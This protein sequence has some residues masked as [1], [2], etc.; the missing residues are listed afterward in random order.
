MA[1]GRNRLFLRAC[2]LTA[3]STNCTL[4][5]TVFTARCD[6]PWSPMLKNPS[7]QCHL[8]KWIYTQ[9]HRVDPSSVS[10]AQ[11]SHSA[12]VFSSTLLPPSTPL[13]RNSPCRCHC[14]SPPLAAAIAA[15]PLL[16]RR[17]CRRNHRRE[18]TEVCREEE[19]LSSSCILTNLPRRAANALLHSWKV[20]FLF[21]SA[22][23]YVV[24]LLLLSMEISSVYRV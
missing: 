7:G 11:P 17:H 24:V 22:M 1:I 23:F 20:G 6:I 5:W 14:C 18:A 9:S 13:P 3:H 4:G 12:A 2:F 19:E 21:M 15:L 16:R 8:K 10:K